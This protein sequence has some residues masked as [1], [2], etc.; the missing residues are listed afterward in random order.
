MPNVLRNIPSVSELLESPP[1]KSLVH[2]VNRNVV[3]TGVRQFLD[4]MRMQVQSAAA[5]VHVPA[6][7][8][9]AQRIADWIATDQRR[10]LVPVINATGT[11]LS[12]EL[13]RV[14]LA[15][16]AIQA[17]ATVA[18]GYSNVEIELDS[19]EHCQR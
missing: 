17:I 8:E 10:S 2:R 13:G 14:P 9:L 3:V 7:S 18:R 16:E 5:N 1:L 19:G 15:E 6:P 12:T 11:I 4:D